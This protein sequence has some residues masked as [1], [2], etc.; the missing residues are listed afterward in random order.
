MLIDDP[1]MIGA[2]L[3]C[4]HCG[5]AL[6]L[7]PA[8]FNS[9]SFSSHTSQSP[10]IPDATAD[11][12]SASCAASTYDATG[13]KATEEDDA[14]SG[15]VQNDVECTDKVA[16][17]QAA[18]NVS[19]LLPLPPPVRRPSAPA[20]EGATKQIP[21]PPPPVRSLEDPLLPSVGKKTPNAIDHLPTGSQNPA[22]EGGISVT[23]LAISPSRKWLLV[24]VALC[25]V[26]LTGV[27]IFLVA[28]TSSQQ[29][30][31]QDE[32]H[33]KIGKKIENANLGENSDSTKVVR[34]TERDVSETEEAADVTPKSEAKVSGALEV[35]EAEKTWTPGEAETSSQTTDETLVADLSAPLE[36]DSADKNTTAPS[37]SKD[38]T[39]L[40]AGGS[41]GVSVPA[42]LDVEAAKQNA[43]PL[44]FTVPARPILETPEGTAPETAVWPPPEWGSQ[45]AVS[46]EANE[47]PKST[48]SESTLP[49]EHERLLGIIR[50]EADTND[51][52]AKNTQNKPNASGVENTADS[53]STDSNDSTADSTLAKSDASD[54]S[55]ASVDAGYVNDQ[56]GE[57]ETV[58]LADDLPQVSVDERLKRSVAGVDFRQTALADAFFVVGDL[59]TIPTILDWNAIDLEDIVAM[60]QHPLFV[61]SQPAELKL[62]KTTYLDILKEVTE[63]HG[64]TWNVERDRFIRITRSGMTT[65]DQVI[66]KNYPLSEFLAKQEDTEK[67][68][69]LSNVAEMVR[70]VAVATPV[71]H[72][73]L[74]DTN[75]GAASFNNA[76]TDANTGAREAGVSELVGEES[77]PSS[78][79][80]EQIEANGENGEHKETGNSSEKNENT[81][82]DV[83]SVTFDGTTLS[84]TVV[85]PMTTHQR[86][87]YFLQ[88][89]VESRNLF[90]DKRLSES[91]DKT[92]KRLAEPMTW[93]MYEKRPLQEVLRSL[94]K[95]T[96]LTIVADWTQ[97]DQV[98]VTPETPVELR[99]EQI[100]L[101]ELLT[102]L[103][104]TLP[105]DFHLVGPGVVE[106]TSRDAVADSLEVACYPLDAFQ[107][108]ET[109]RNAIPERLQTAIPRLERYPLFID[110]VSNR[111]FVACPKNEMEQIRQQLPKMLK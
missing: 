107:G 75:T 72:H 96:K 108:G 94:A 53:L 104:D 15:E 13:S 17:L 9:P 52:S 24:T 81:Q 18:E 14:K 19:H 97:L 91:V 26:F 8:D 71:K 27:L 5:T 20:A 95:V 103:G 64:L 50:G 16:G 35:A 102:T 100:S 3:E 48:V 6:F 83:A 73:D 60:R 57:E 41:A 33:V 51:E 84:I 37:V 76:G 40:P 36:S 43:Q 105:V 110:S 109:E 74:S 4:P 42:M 87:Q 88:L 29:L 45:A 47:V 66:E 89:L 22:E 62:V 32:K 46:A 49:S 30:S 111:L 2:V 90:P 79:G 55:E 68:N 58:E 78:P 7:D 80:L 1:S 98:E 99:G 10:P 59:S 31:H 23:E 86:V 70:L 11:T 25:C 67:Q 106:M 101:T 65:P 21:V 61:S 82:K 28:R 92:E 39:A 85:A 38:V 54:I 34:N 12:S 63:K 56:G 44:D 77:N 69:D 93:M